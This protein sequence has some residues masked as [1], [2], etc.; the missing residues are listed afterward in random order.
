MVFAPSGCRVLEIFNPSF[1]NLCYRMLAAR[2]GAKYQSV[3]GISLKSEPNAPAE[4][5]GD[6][7]LGSDVVELIMYSA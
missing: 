3:Y 7:V 6:I 1:T 4:T 5:A 2:C